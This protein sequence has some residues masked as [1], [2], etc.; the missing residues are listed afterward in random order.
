MY[1][2]HP[3]SQ[4]KNTGID[5]DSYTLICHTHKNT[6]PPWCHPFS[7]PFT[8][9]SIPPHP[10]INIF[11]IHFH[12]FFAYDLNIFLC[13]ST[14]LLKLPPHNQVLLPTYMSFPGGAGV[15][16]LPAYAGDMALIPAW[17]SPR[18]GNGNPLQCSC[19]GNPMDRRD[20]R[21][22]VHGVAK[23]LDVT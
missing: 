19:L 15:K 12:S 21:A 9:T 10:H 18:E 17:R 14:L 1:L 2:P 3:D 23:E 4:V 11:P 5:S 6:N 13:I 20:W 8:N 16:N 7:C 22:T